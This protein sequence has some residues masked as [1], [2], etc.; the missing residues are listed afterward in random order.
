MRPDFFPDTVAN[1]MEDRDKWGSLATVYVMM[2]RFEEAIEACNEG[3][4]FNAINDHQKILL[5][6]MR[7]RAKFYLATNY[8]SWK[9][10]DA[11][12]PI[13]GSADTNI[14]LLKEAWADTEYLIEQFRQ[15]NWP[16]NTNFISDLWASIASVL[17]K[18]KDTLFLLKEAAEARPSED[19]QQALE[20][21]M[22]STDILTASTPI[23]QPKKRHS[24]SL[25]KIT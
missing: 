6:V 2:S 25:K 10:K 23:V 19:L 9:D 13:S 20:L 1:T 18:Q 8:A 22:P 4:K 12:Y 3:L 5:I 11:V 15:L 17:N 21:I 24:N 7:A 16:P 14:P